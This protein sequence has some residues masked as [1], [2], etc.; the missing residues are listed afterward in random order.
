V[1]D[2]RIVNLLAEIRDN[3][4]EM[5]E[6]QR[7]Q[8]EIAQRHLEQGKA[9]IAESLQLQREAVSRTRTIAR[10]AIP[11]ILACIAAIAYLVLRYF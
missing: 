9:Q 11:G 8:L 6:R 7:A 5:L 10:L 3:Q 1:S 2:E 4:R